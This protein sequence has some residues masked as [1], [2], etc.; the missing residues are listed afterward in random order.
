RKA[1]W[2]PTVDSRS[3]T[4]RTGKGLRRRARSEANART[5][6][7]AGPSFPDNDTG[8]PTTTSTASDSAASAAIRS[9]SPGPRR[10]VSRGTARVPEGSDRATPMR[11]SP[12]STAS[13]TPPRI[14]R[15]L[16]G[17][18][19]LRPDR[20][21]DLTERFVDLAGVGT[22][23]LGDVRLAATSTAEDS[24]GELG[25][26]ARGQLPVPCR[27]VEGDDDG[28]T[29]TRDAGDRHN[30]GPLPRHPTADVERQLAQVAGR[31]PL[32]R[33]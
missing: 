6:L 12:T 4:S 25:Q 7:A 15:P 5:L 13:R 21:L 20:L 16:S 9:R 18:G 28:R 32:G 10:I 3:S 24:G 11:T 17:A 19:D 23:T 29:A 8:R 31:S 1:W 14:A 26:L 22:A 2:A 33:A 27:V 30:G